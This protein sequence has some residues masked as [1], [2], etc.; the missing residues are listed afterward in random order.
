MALPLRPTPDALVEHAYGDFDENGNPLGIENEMVAIN[1]E[2][3][4]ADNFS[5]R[6]LPPEGG[7]AVKTS[8]L[9]ADVAAGGLDSIPGAND[10]L[11][12]FDVV[13]D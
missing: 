5:L 9:A 10:I 3:Q 1:A 8:D 6:H 4:R 2:C 11:V 7:G 13:V 12:S